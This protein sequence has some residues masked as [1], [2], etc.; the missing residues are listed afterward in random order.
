MKKLPNYYVD[1]KIK[2]NKKDGFY[3]YQDNNKYLFAQGI[4]R[5]KIKE[6]DL[7]DDYIKIWLY[8]RHL[9]L[10]LKNI[11]DVY[12]KPNFHTNHYRKDDSLYISYKNKLNI[13]KD[14]HCN[15]Y[16]VVIYGPEIDHFIN[17]LEKYKYKLETIN[18]IKYLMDKK[19]KWY[20]Y[21][22]KHNWNGNYFFTSDKV[23]KEIY[24]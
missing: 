7:S 10:S 16:D 12:Y 21:W 6:E 17:E 4:Y 13:N 18:K 5:T 1:G 24:K 9:Y 11:K 22:D 8:P 20:R 3:Y 2:H 23:W 14:G 15:N 19:D